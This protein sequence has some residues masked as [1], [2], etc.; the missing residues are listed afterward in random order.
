[1]PAAPILMFVVIACVIVGV[2]VGQIIWARKRCEALAAL[3]AQLGLTFD[4]DREHGIA[5]RYRF[6]DQLRKGSNRYAMNVLSGA[7]EGHSLTVFDYHY[8]TYSRDS[9]GHRQT[10]H[11]WFS[12]FVLALPRHFPELTIRE[13][14]FFAK[15][16]QAVGFD[17][18]DFESHEFSRAFNVRS[19]QKKFAY[20]IC[21]AQM[22]DYLLANRD[23]SIEIEGTA[24]ALEFG[25][26]LT[27]EQV[28]VN[29]RRLLDVRSRIPDYLFDG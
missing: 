10:H 11:H 19:R 23:L 2:I 29:I 7:V 5:E 17:D 6:L 4:P 26:R 27:P 21:N 1:M 13:E 16:A 22:I 15:I 25:R 20:D 28:S 9:K 14:G 8:E 12:Y 24:L 18:I 3:A